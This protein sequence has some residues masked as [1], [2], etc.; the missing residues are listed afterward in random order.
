MLLG[1][2]DFTCFFDESLL[3]VGLAPKQQL[4]NN[5][6]IHCYW[7]ILITLFNIAE[8]YINI[9]VPVSAAIASTTMQYADSLPSISSIFPCFYY[10]GECSSSNISSMQ[11][12]SSQIAPPK[13]STLSI[14]IRSLYWIEDYYFEWIRNDSLARDEVDLQNLPLGSIYPLAWICLL[15]R[16]CL[17]SAGLEEYI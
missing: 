10:W 17:I 12:S 5:T 14:A 8:T 4:I 1:R 9:I 16:V 6:V 7:I 15:I 3:F 2:E 13:D 11:P